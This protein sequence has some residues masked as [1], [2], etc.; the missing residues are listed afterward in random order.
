MVP[1]IPRQSYEDDKHKS[2]D[3]WPEFTYSNFIDPYQPSGQDDLAQTSFHP[4]E[5]VPHVQC[6]ECLPVRAYYFLATVEGDGHAKV[7]IAYENI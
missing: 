1:R 2:S 3:D 6:L 4:H 5:A 7:L